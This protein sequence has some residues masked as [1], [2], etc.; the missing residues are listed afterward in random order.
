MWMGYGSCLK[1]Q[2]FHFLFVGDIILWKNFEE[3]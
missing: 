3:W 1:M 2:G